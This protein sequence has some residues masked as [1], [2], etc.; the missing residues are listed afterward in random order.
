[1]VPANDLIS[2]KNI[3]HVIQTVTIFIKH[4]CSKSKRFGLALI[5]LN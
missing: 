1:M 5:R 4:H 3:K 2:L